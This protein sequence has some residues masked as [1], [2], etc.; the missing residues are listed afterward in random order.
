MSV[1]EVNGGYVIDFTLNHER[2]RETIPAPHNKTASKRIEEQETIYKMAISLNDKSIASRFPNS[3]II[4]R[5]FD[6]GCNFTIH[7]Y[8]NIWFK[9]KQRN[10]SHTTIR[11]YSQK[12]NSYIKPNWGDLLLTEFKASMFDEWASESLLSGKSINE[13]RNVLKQ[14][15]NRALMDE[16]IEKNPA[17]Q[18]ERYKQASKE[19]NPFNKI[20]IKK[21]LCS[22]ES[23]YKYFYK[24]AIFTGLRTGELLGL[25]W[26]DVDLNKKVAHIRLSITNGIE[27]APKTIGSIRSIELNSEAVSALKCIKQSEYF[28]SYRVFIDPRTMKEYKY[29]DGL[30]KY[31]WK[32]ALE[33][34]QIPYRYP[35][36]CRHTY[37]SMMLSQGK[38][39]LWV[40]RQMGHADWG[41]IRKTYGRWVPQ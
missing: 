40:A 9:Q 39:P 6:T 7:D 27:K 30:R 21:I 25:R 5:A 36:Q 3:K 35:Y 19:P 17:E 15:F 29:A 1:K 37:A 20:E 13:T 28:H 41:M 31:V 16:V 22:L 33:Q 10:W 11:G 4:Q 38:N 12:Y 8:S 24:F 26:Q 18:I 14:I 32:P 2:Y 34:A 23:P